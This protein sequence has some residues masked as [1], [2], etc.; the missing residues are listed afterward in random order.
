M[1]YCFNF[2]FFHQSSIPSTDPHNPQSRDPRIREDDVPFY[3]IITL[4]FRL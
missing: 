4:G 3:E 2:L 1:R